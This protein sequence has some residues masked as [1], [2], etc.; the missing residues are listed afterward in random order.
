VSRVEEARH[1][2][3][4]TNFVTR[5][6]GDGNFGTNF[7]TPSISALARR[8]IGIFAHPVLAPWGILNCPT[9]FDRRS[10][11]F[12]CGTG[13]SEQFDNLGWQSRARHR[14]CATPPPRVLQ[15]GHTT[16]HMVIAYVA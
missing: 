7:V 2:N 15:A 11:D 8:P 14:R 10:D 4:V 3:F 12:L 16:R 9:R 13:A 5:R 6:V 1:R